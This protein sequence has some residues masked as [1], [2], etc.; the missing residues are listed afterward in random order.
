MSTTTTEDTRHHVVIIGCGFGGLFAAKALRRAPVRVTLIDRTNHHLFQP[1]LYQVTTGILSEGQIAPA[2]PR[3]AA[4]SSVATGG[5]GR[6]GFHR[7]GG[8]HG[9]HHR[10]RRQ[11]GHV[12]LRQPHCGRWRGDLLLRSRRVPRAAACG[13]KSLNDALLPARGDLRGVRAGRAGGGRGPPS[14]PDDLRGDR[15]RAER[16]GDGRTAQG[17]LPARP[18]AQ[19]PAHRSPTRPASSWSRGAIASSPPWASASH[20]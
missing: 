7:S 1:L 9:D 4:P 12:L 3:R 18:A 14:G 11:P 16:R 8:P 5:P 19:L 10:A 13:M 15:R 20:G 2:G 17:A 6:G